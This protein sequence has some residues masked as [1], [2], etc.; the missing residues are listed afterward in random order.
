MAQRA[1]F[2]VTVYM[3]TLYFISPININLQNLHK[4]SPSCSRGSAGYTGLPDSL[5]A[6]ADPQA[7]KLIFTQWLGLA[8]DIIIILINS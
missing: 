7:V 4:V 3:N 5:A 1:N 6:I 8:R 2:F